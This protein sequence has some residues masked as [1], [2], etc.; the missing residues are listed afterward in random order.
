MAR[1]ISDTGPLIAFGK[2][3]LLSVARRL[4]TRFGIPDAVWRECLGRGGEDTL[5]IEEAVREGWLEVL[6]PGSFG[7]PSGGP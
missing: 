5:R 7:W 1:V 6:P 2:A 3:D 4:F